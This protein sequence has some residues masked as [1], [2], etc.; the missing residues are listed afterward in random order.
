MTLTHPDLSDSA[1]IQSEDKFIT[2]EDEI[3]FTVIRCLLAF[4]FS[5][6]SFLGVLASIIL[7]NRS[8]KWDL[9]AFFI[10]C[11]IASLVSYIKGKNKLT[12]LKN[13]KNEILIRY[14]NEILETN[15]INHSVED[16]LYF[17]RD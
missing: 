11:L 13:E 5:M 1:I 3:V 17:Y 6:T 16:G 9:L 15:K 14:R 4:I 12:L 10:F 7:V 8:D 2:L